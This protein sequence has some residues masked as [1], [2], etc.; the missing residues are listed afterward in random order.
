MRISPKTSQLIFASFIVMLLLFSLPPAVKSADNTVPHSEFIEEYFWTYGCTPTAASIVLSYW[1]SANRPKHVLWDY[2]NFTGMGTLIDYYF[3]DACGENVPNTIVELKNSLGSDYNAGT[4]TGPG[5]TKPWDIDNGVAAVTNSINGYLFNSYKACDAIWPEIFGDWCWDYITQEI[6]LGRPFIWSTGNIDLNGHTVAAWGYTDDKFVIVYDTWSPGGRE[7]WYYTHYLGDP[8]NSI[9]STQVN[10]VVPP[11]SWERDDVD[12]LLDDPIGDEQVFAGVPY[13]ILWYQFGGQA[14]YQIDHVDIYYSLNQGRTWDNYVGTSQIYSGNRLGGFLW[15]VPDITSTDVRLRIMAYDSDNNYIAGDGSRQDFTIVRDMDAPTGNI[16]I[17]GVLNIGEV[18]TSDPAVDLTLACTD[19]PADAASGCAE[20][21]LSND[22]ITWTP[23]ESYATARSWTL[24]A[25]DG[26]KTVYVQYKDVVGNESAV[27]SDMIILD[28]TGPVGT[29]LINNGAEYT[30]SRE[31]VLNLASNDAVEMRFWDYHVNLWTAW[32]S[33]ST[34]KPWTLNGPD[35]GAKLIRVTFRDIVDNISTISDT[36]VLDTRA[37]GG[38]IAI[39][40]GAGFTNSTVATL[41]MTCTDYDSG[42]SEMRLSDDDTTWTGWEPVAASKPWILPALDET[43]TVYAQYRDNVG[44][45]SGSAYDTIIYE[46]V[47]P[48]GTV[49]INNGI[50]HS[51]TEAVTLALSCTDATS[52]C[53]QMRV[54]NDNENWSAWEPIAAS[55]TWML[56]SGDDSKTV[57]G[58]FK[59]LADNVATV[60][61]SIVMENILTLATIDTSTTT[62]NVGSYSDVAVDSKGKIHISYVHEVFDWVYGDFVYD[63]KY[64]TNAGGTWTIAV[65]DSGILAPGFTSIALDSSD[66]VHISYPHWDA[67]TGDKTV[68]YT[69]N[70]GGSWV[71]TPVTSIALGRGGD[72]AAIAVDSNDH[73]HICYTAAGSIMYATNGSGTWDSVTIGSGDIYSAI[74]LDSADHAHISYYDAIPNGGELHYATNASGAWVNTRIDG[75]PASGRYTSIAVD[76]NDAVHIGYQRYTTPNDQLKYAT[77]ASGAWATSIVES[78][79]DVGAY[80]SIAVDSYNGVHISYQDTT[81]G[82]IKYATN[83]D[84]PWF[85]STVDSENYIGQYASIAID[86]NNRIH[87]SYQGQGDLRYATSTVIGPDTDSDGLLDGADNCILVAN[88]TQRDTDGDGFGNICDPDFDGNLVVN[89][90]DLS[91][92]KSMF[93]TADPHAD[94]DGS[95]VVNAGD[96][97]ILKSF[98]FNAPGPSGLV[99]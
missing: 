3:Q 46:T 90:A 5:T 40:N 60:S 91:Y 84:G 49:T 56:T 64:A 30:T 53:N 72:S 68:Q 88:S 8:D 70:A 34:T 62:G 32:E 51:N 23:W 93:F 78:T 99:P 22:N 79:A 43:K 71:S 18:Y 13:Q 42:C 67:T 36:I 65:I 9:E 75:A 11:N 76:S 6:D 16:L 12:I 41:S 66:H 55:R 61:D 73:A 59:D 17:N 1:D 50:E 81:L 39:N 45:I 82:D 47:A 95:G 26:S 25:G 58:Q 10:A 92:L 44:H 94:L 74:A 21:R 14:Q 29:I 96:L 31:V 97:A 80:T 69:T 24:S 27:F 20:K 83:V 28:T 48:A 4:C 33:F 57:Y 63:V 7:D 86:A 52:G 19:L 35:S 77:N 15:H 98:F 87:I 85:I 89:A 54:S 38:T 37:P 2:Y